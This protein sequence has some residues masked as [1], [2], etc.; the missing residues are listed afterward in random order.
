METNDSN[1][2]LKDLDT[3]LGIRR[4]HVSE[5]VGAV[6]VFNLSRDLQ[7]RESAEDA[8]QREH[9]FLESVIQTAQTIILVV[10]PEGRIV[11]FNAYMADI[12]GWK[13]EDVKGLDWCDTFVPEVR[14]VI[15]RAQFGRSL[16][17]NRTT[18]RSNVYPILTKDGRLR[19]I[20]WF[21]RL[22]ED[23]NGAVIG[24]LAIG[25]DITDRRRAQELLATSQERYR[26]LLESVTDYVYTVKVEFG[27]AVSTLHGP[28]CEA[29]TGYVPQDYQE[30]PNLW[31]QMIYAEDRTAVIEQASS[32]IAGQNPLPIEHRILHKDGSIRW[33]RNT[34]V[35]R[36]DDAGR[37][38]LYEGVIINITE[39]K[40]TEEKLQDEERFLSNIFTSVQ[41]G[42][43][44]ID[45]DMGIIRVNPKMEQWF[46]HALPLAGKK[47]YE[48]F[49]GRKER[50]EL[51][52]TIHTLNTGQ[53]AY[54]VVPKRDANNQ[55][56]GWFDLYSF[57]FRDQATGAMKG[58]IE[59]VRDITERRKTETE[60]EKRNL[61]L[62]RANENLER[63]QM[64]KDEFLAMI[65]HDLRTPLVTGLGYV[66][67]LLNGEFGPLSEDAGSGMK[68]ALRNLKRL[69]T[70]IDDVLN[71][72]TV[73]MQNYRE[74]LTL[75]PI[76]LQR[77]YRECASEL[78]IRCGRPA[79]S[80]TLDMPQ[81]LP[82]VL[83]NIDMIRRVLANL[84][85]N[86]HKH[87]GANAHITLS[88]HPV[89]NH[90]VQLGIRDNGPGMPP[91]IRVRAFESF[92]KSGKSRDG[93]GLGLAIVRYIVKAHGSEAQL[94][95]EEGRGTVIHFTLPVAQS[96][97]PAVAPAGPA[98]AVPESEP[99][100]RVGARV[101][102]VDD[103]PDT[104]EFV[105]L[106][107]D[108]H[109]Y[110]V[111]P[112]PSSEEALVLLENAVIDLAL[113]DMTLGGMDGVEL[114]R[115]LKEK[116]RSRDLPVYMFTARADE[117]ARRRAEDAGC[118]GYIIKPITMDAFLHTLQMA[119]VKNSK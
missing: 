65:S 46:S 114:C 67:M 68:V 59:Y 45:S 96:A 80:V 10:D 63:L 4:P 72:Q 110:R 57:P 26:R 44:V 38:I 89:D 11:L 99:L 20:E 51:C 70:L 34:I 43:T 85:N 24:V 7:Q 9:A 97:A 82:P 115:R 60:L 27:R 40:R 53:A 77:L 71:Y 94:E 78:C 23:R 106:L 66:D 19:D 117:S 47:C 104:L 83:G 28:G 31:Y 112:A 14:R 16:S 111:L 42:I 75:A 62:M 52:P 37:V 101:L 2:L 93:S 107:L 91:D 118:D 69:Q 3:K 15:F 39:R 100:A 61:D 87:A 33:I 109:G 21:D 84:L 50:C 29:V 81:D 76:D 98:L 105:G 13:L 108:K 116:Y 73:S 55:V 79:D 74:R 8:L 25:Q 54:E 56:V 119:L 88:A 18:T 30:D 6:D 41:D 48:A 35:I 32:A 36:R 5:S 58:V 22:L 17:R 12:S 95:S 1:D 102:V 113:I 92:V 86:A 64:A 90:R 49:H 103:D